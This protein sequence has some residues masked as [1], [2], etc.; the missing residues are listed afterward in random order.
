M[1]NTP[2]FPEKEIRAR[3]AA[4][5]SPSAEEA[6]RLGH[7]Y[8]GTEHLFIAMTKVEGG[9]TAS[10]LKRAGLNPRHVRNE[11]RRESG[12]GEGSIDTVLPL[13]PRAGMVLSI[14][15]FFAE[16][17]GVEEIEEVHLLLAMLQEGEGLPIRKL[18]EMGFNVNA[19][20]NQL[21]N[22]AYEKDLAGV[23]PSI[24]LQDSSLFNSSD[25]DDLASEEFFPG[26]DA[27][28]EIKPGS[29][30]PTPLLDKYGRDLMEQAANGKIGPAIAREREI[31]AVARTLA[32]SKKN[33]PL[34]LGDAGVGKTAVVE[35]LAY[36]IHNRSAPPSLLNKRL[37]QVEIGT[38]VAGTSLRGQFEERLIGIVEEAKNAGNV[39]LFIDEIHTIVGAGDTIDSNLDAANILKPALARGEIV[40]IGATTHAEYQR[41]IAQDPAL[42]R[43]FR[44]IDIEEP[45]EE[46]SLTILAGQR[47]RLEDHHGV[48]IRPEALEASVRMSVRY[49]TDRRL[50]DKAIDLLDEACA[51]VVIST[52]APDDPERLMDVRVENVAAVL[53]DWTGIPVNELTKDE[54]RRLTE[55]EPELLKRVI[56]QDHAVQTVADAIKTARAGLHDPNRPIGVFLFLGPSGVGK[57][58]LA[59]ALANFMFGD[60]EAMI[61]LDMSEFH[62]AHTVARLIGAP[63]GY[64][65]SNRGGQLTDAL[66]RRPYSVVLLDEVE[67]AAPE[68]FDIFLQVFDEGRLS[69]AHGGT[70]DARHAVFI[71]T[72]NIGTEEASKPL[73]FVGSERMP[74][75]SA[76]LNRYF[77]PEFLNRLDE[78]VTFKPLTQDVLSKILDL[79]LQDLHKRLQ[80]QHLTLELSDDAREL[81]LAQGHDP[82]HGARPLRRAVERLLIRP[83]SGRI[84][85][86]AFANN[87][88]IHTHVENGKLVFTASPAP[89]DEGEAERT[90]SARTFNANALS[91]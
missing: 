53:S 40:C 23:P 27:D 42:D 39:I 74:D 10:L 50:P 6:R 22:E 31:R 12:S 37:V 14:A 77:R 33:N 7:N 63:P 54:K 73:G 4:L 41:A 57:T 38:L 70:V 16:R 65:D 89:Q 26:V 67:K 44:P 20:L 84:V 79:N 56:G 58:E 2:E 30:A 81:I 90:I 52:I 59:R 18:A 45:S 51:R 55:L 72:S 69:D 17:D 62:D 49:M 86:D 36:A 91:D 3:C 60:D 78:V 87:D 32:R 66:H 8:I 76:Y 35:G 5:L 1:S 15:M 75:Y 21:L 43:R 19:W 83:L 85:E 71:M 68:V 61:R 48:T 82:I 88:I 64:K 34:L 11:I 47:Q 24:P 9:A 46:D 25:F 13:T 29:R 80:S 28:A